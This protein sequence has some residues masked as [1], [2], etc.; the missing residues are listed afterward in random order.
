[1]LKPKY[2]GFSRLLATVHFVPFLIQQIPRTPERNRQRASGRRGRD[3]RR[4]T[5][6]STGLYG[7]HFIYLTINQ[8]VFQE[9]HQAKYNMT[10]ITTYNK[11]PPPQTSAAY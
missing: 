9:C 3:W 10:E 6:D 4:A 11:T 1:M 5:P 8:S 2:T 7:Q